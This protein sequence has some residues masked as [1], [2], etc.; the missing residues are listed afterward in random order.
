LQPT[1][2]EAIQRF[3]QAKT[4]PELAELYTPEMEVQCNVARGNGKKADAVYKGRTMIAWTDGTETWKPFR[5]PHNAGTNPEYTDRPMS[6]NLEKHVEGIGMTGWNWVKRVSK[7]VGFDF[8]AI[9]GHSDRHTRKCTDEEL[10]KIRE[11]VSNI[12][13][14]ELRRSTGGSGLHIYVKVND[15]PTENHHEHAALARAI[16]GMISGTVGFD[17]G[18]KLDAM[19]GNMWV[20]H[21]KMEGTDGLRLLKSATTKC[22][23]PINWRDHIPV[24]RGDRRKTVPNQLDANMEDAFNALANKR[25]GVPLDDSHKALIKHLEESGACVVWDADRGMLTAHTFELALAAEKLQFRGIFKTLATG[26]ERGTDINCFAYPMKGGAWNVRRFTKGVEEA[27]TWSQDSAGWTYCYLNSP[28]DVETAVRAAGGQEDASSY[29][30]KA[31]KDAQTAV[32]SLGAS[33]TL[34]EWA[35]HR[36]ASLQKTT[37]NKLIVQIERLKDETETLQDW[38]PKGKN[39]R[40]VITLPPSEG[41]MDIDT[42]DADN[43]LRHIVTHDHIDAGWALA[44]ED[45]WV[46]EPAANIKLALKSLGRKTSEAD[47]M[48]GNAI[49]KPWTLVNRPFKDEYPGNRIWNRTCAQLR[50]KPTVDKDKDSLHHP[51]WDKIFAHLGKGLD[52]GVRQNSWCIEHGITTGADWLR[53]WVASLFQFPEQPLPYLFFFG[54]Q[55]VGK[56]TLQEALEI[57]ITDKGVVRANNA[58]TSEQAFNGELTS[59]VVCVV[60][61][62][63]LGGKNKKS[64]A[65]NRMKDW[66]VGRTIQLHVKH[67][68]PYSVPNT[69]HWIQIANNVNYCPLFPG[70]TRITMIEVGEIDPANLVPKAQLFKS[71]EL[72]A[73]DFLASM[74]ALELPPTNDRMNIP[75]IETYQKRIAA[76]SNNDPVEDFLAFGLQHVQG[77]LISVQ[78]AYN[79]YTSWIKS[80]YPLETPVSNLAFSRHPKILKIKGRKKTSQLNY[81]ANVSEHP[82]SHRDPIVVKNGH[83]YSVT[84]EAL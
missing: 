13:W 4:H 30:F 9:A 37:D 32:T 49:L 72:E 44:V 59:A 33:L 1:R 36:K 69:T 27:P 22:E 39:W 43:L 65:Y 14:V 7:Y 50:Y 53:C 28:L 35:E 10:S 11:L 66:V 18:A 64:T 84:G 83:L 46:D 20:W 52:D 71:L 68:T 75:V 26:T 2:T 70:D 77:Y 79:L 48:M 51:H 63:D 62:L 41:Y 17:F 61:E 45:N 24:I 38:I 31:A 34:P 3:L 5:I 15:I 54:E 74:F 16:L 29:F 12:P 58:L 82:G 80:M 42:N 19:G 55:N 47:Q 8:D 57:L 40:K 21:R 78:D 76:E 60:E 81:L 67:M 23:V 6:F 25:S 56:S 73:P